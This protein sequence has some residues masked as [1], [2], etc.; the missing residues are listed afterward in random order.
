[1]RSQLSGWKTVLAQLGFRRTGTHRKTRLASVHRRLRLESLESRNL[2]AITVNTAVDE[3]DFSISD[4][5]RSL[6]D[7]ILFALPG[8]GIITFDSSLNGA[9]INLAAALGTIDIEESIIID[10]SNLPDGITINGNDPSDDPLDGIRIFNIT[11]PT[12][13][14][15]P[16]HV[17]IKNLTLE[18]GD[19]GFEDGGAIKSAGRLTLIDCT[20][21][22]NQAAL[23]SGGGVFVQVAGGGATP[24]TVLT[25][26]DCVFEE[27]EATS[28]A[29][30]G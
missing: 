26:E 17:T 8:D 6:R 1:M 23:A 16:P 12:S 15:A 22:S 9:S 28:G 21:Q 3:Q 10:A 20:I 29:G 11:D 19:A 2:L 25:I 30:R 4:G 13:G 7:A 24:R 18:D 5:D 27:N 14:S